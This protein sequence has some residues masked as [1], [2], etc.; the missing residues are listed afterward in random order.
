MAKDGVFAK[1][2]EDVVLVSCLM[3]T[4]S[5]KIYRETDFITVTNRGPVS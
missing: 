4:D 2:E 5:S 1:E 3:A